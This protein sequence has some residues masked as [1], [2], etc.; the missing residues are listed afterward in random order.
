M[1]SEVLHGEY[2][3]GNQSRGQMDSN[4]WINAIDSLRSRVPFHASS[5]KN[6]TQEAGIRHHSTTAYCPWANGTIE[7]LYR[8]V[9]R[10]CWALQSE[11]KLPAPE[12]PAVVEG[13]QNILNQSP[14]ER[15][16]KKGDGAY[17]TPMK[18]FLGMNPAPIINCL[19]PL[20]GFDNIESISEESAK[21][22]IDIESLQQAMGKVHKEVA[23]RNEKS[24]TRARAINIARTNVVTVNFTIGDYVM[25]R[26][27]TNCSH[28]MEAS[29]YG[30]WEWLDPLRPQCLKSR[31]CHKSR[32][33]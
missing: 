14:L 9:L 6:L 21:A 2:Q 31:I 33:K 10:A 13:I 12:W 20:L 32:R 3:W 24:Q 15:L 30:P 26:R 25:S 4:F 7:S 1:A 29:W 16:G 28:K 22:L 17:L 23:K 19:Y 5:M 11:W 8:E 18:V 27:C